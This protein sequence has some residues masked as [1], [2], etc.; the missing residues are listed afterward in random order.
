MD[1]LQQ[2]QID[3][4]AYLDT[5]PAFT[6]V[7]TFVVRPRSAEEATLLQTSIDAAL[8]CVTPKNGKG[9]IA[10]MILMPDA[11]VPTDRQPGPMLQPRITVQIIEYPIINESDSGTRLSAEQLA[12]EVVRALHVHPMGGGRLIRA[13]ERG[14]LQQMDMSDEGK[15]AWAVHL[16]CFYQLEEAEHVAAPGISVSAGNVTLSIPAGASGYYTTDR[17]FPTPDNG[18][19]WDGTPFA[20]PSANYV[21]VVAYQTGLYPSP[22][23][24][25]Y[26]A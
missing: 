22:M 20:A 13:Q 25:K 2:I 21:R 23:K 4:R 19:L 14:A 8:N 1:P 3:V 11:D 10:A 5:L 17:S 9:G 24:E 18:T 15:I 12:L 6:Y 26:F 16:A 7:P